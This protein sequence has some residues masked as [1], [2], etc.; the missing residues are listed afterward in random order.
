MNVEGGVDKNA[1]GQLMGAN[2][3]DSITNLAR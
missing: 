1:A 2:R 3:L